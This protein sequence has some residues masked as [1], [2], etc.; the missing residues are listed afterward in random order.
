MDSDGKVRPRA[1]DWTLR[2]VELEL[3]G[4]AADLPNWRLA[5]NGRRLVLDVATR[6]SATVPPPGGGADPASLA[7]EDAQRTAVL[8]LAMLG[9]RCASTS[10][11]LL[12]TGYAFEAG[13]P[14]RRLFETT[15]YS[16]AILD[17]LSGERARNWLQDKYQPSLASLMKKFGTE[18]ER[19]AVDPTTT[20]FNAASH[21]NLR[22]L[23]ALAAVGPNKKVTRLD[24][25]PLRD[26]GVAEYALFMAAFECSVHLGQLELAFGVEVVLPAWFESE[27][28]RWADASR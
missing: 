4:A 13:G 24:V 22:G 6:I 2:E 12:G 11:M 3:F 14:M 18:A 16:R 21:A 5:D 15:S 23:A 27:L 19:Q 25:G 10:M 26:A 9:A 28:N 8:Q 17:D 20:S 1:R 7:T